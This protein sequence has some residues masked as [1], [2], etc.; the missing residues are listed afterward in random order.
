MG[1]E[2]FLATTGQ[3]QALIPEQKETVRVVIAQDSL[4]D[5]CS[6]AIFARH[7][8]CHVTRITPNSRTRDCNVREGEHL[9]LT[10]NLTYDGT[11]DEAQDFLSL[12]SDD[13]GDDAVGLVHDASDAVVFAIA[14]LL[15]Y[16]TFV[17]RP[18]KA[19][20]FVGSFFL[21]Q[22][23]W[24]LKDGKIWHVLATCC[25]KIDFC[26]GS[27]QV[28]AHMHDC[29]HV[30]LLGMLGC[31]VL[32][33]VLRVCCN[34][35]FSRS[36]F[37]LQATSSCPCCFVPVLATAM[38]L[39]ILMACTLGTAADSINVPPPEVLPYGTSVQRTSHALAFTAAPP[40][41]RP[42]PNEHMPVGNTALG[43]TV[44][45]SNTASCLGNV[46][47]GFWTLAPGTALLLPL[48]SSSS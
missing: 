41:L 23:R 33:R 47:Q 12:R 38:M 27:V 31:F 5:W 32:L 35:L 39:L 9:H 17:C 25:Q 1:P 34:D 16:S 28:A 45:T 15:L 21:A 13:G 18:C 4:L 40:V 7:L 43:I 19:V 24:I 11:V 48:A 6:A 46:S 14:S 37:P 2:H 29:S 10:P 44:S 30:L 3:H 8:L 26:R 36:R 22:L 20:V 42:T